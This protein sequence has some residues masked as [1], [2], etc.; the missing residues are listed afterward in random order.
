MNTTVRDDFAAFIE[1]CELFNSDVKLYDSAAK[2]NL[3]FDGKGIYDKKGNLA[4]NEDGMLSYQ[5]HKSSISLSKSTLTFMTS[6]FSLKGYFIDITDTD[7][8]KN[9]Q[10][11][12]SIYN[13][14]VLNIYCE[15]KEA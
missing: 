6:Y 8:T 11:V 15:L 10:I 2:S 12:N 7:G 3:V 5:G 4:Q 9:Y 13:S 14:N 1:D